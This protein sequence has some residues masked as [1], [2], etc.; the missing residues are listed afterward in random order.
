MLRHGELFAV[1]DRH[2]DALPSETGSHGF[3]YGGTRFLSEFSLW[4]EGAR[5]ALLGSTVRDEDALLTV[6]LANPDLL[7]GRETPI[8][9]D[10]IHVFR[11]RFACEDTFYESVRLTNH[12]SIAVEF[13]L[14]FDFA[15]DFAD[16]F[17][18]R[19]VRRAF[20]G[21]ARPP[22][23]SASGLELSYRGLDGLVR[24]TVV[25]CRPEPRTVT[26]TEIAYRVRL[27]PKQSQEIFLSITCIIGGSPSRPPRRDGE[28]AFQRTCDERDGA[29]RRSC[30]IRTSNESFN[31][32]IARST[33][34]LRMMVSQTGQG[35]YPFAGVPWF[36]AIF[37]RDGIITARELLWVDPAVARGVLLT[38]AATQAKDHSDARDAE[39]GKIVHEI[40]SGEM[41]ELGEVPFGC[42]YGTVDATPLFIMLAHGYHAQTGDLATIR[43]L[44]PSILAALEWIE[45]HGDLD[46]DGFIEY[47]RRAPDG[48][49]Q[50]GWKDS[51][52][53]IFHADG[54]PAEGPIALCE[55]QGY[56]YAA[57]VAVA[58]LASLLGDAALSRHQQ[59]EAAALRRRF[60]DRFWC[61]ELGTFVLAL[62]GDKEPCR[63]RT[64]NAGHCLFS[65]IATEEQ[66]LLL[67]STLMTEDAFS[68]WGL[69]T[70]SARERRYNPM[71][72]H[73]GSV[74]PHDTAIGA[75][76]M[77]RY[78]AREPVLR[79]LDG[80]FQASAYMDF[81]RLPELFCGFHARPGQGP[82]LYPL[83]CSPQAW[84]AGSVFMLL[85][86]C[87]GLEIHGA[88]R[89]AIFRRPV[90]PSWLDWVE[91]TGL[92]V[93]DTT[94]DLLLRRVR[95]GVTIELVS[96]VGDATVQVTKSI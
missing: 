83:A 12:G 4:M 36:N 30:R 3:Y 25:Q 95:A 6:D 66:A 10:T 37:G 41:A 21:D 20:R 49:V 79:L 35:I 67:S 50:Q 93:G 68:G 92:R 64:S 46:G 17:E 48:L 85:E 42:Y 84:A 27:E 88:A 75:A 23:R 24:S 16:I 8:L 14:S 28:V 40:R 62:D 78:G 7:R 32:W 15:S 5:P 70:V 61:E 22:R 69:R 51:N 72:Y 9:R 18:V 11:S 76:G 52:D 57:R 90:L 82:T 94:L 34:D 31:D 54:R 45:T 26:D 87:L 77:A 55:V 63:V 80:L 39:P 86:A 19:G 13:D 89:T 65:G 96:K 2:G 59:S 56:A 91:L 38:L 60:T 71:S 44:W 58:E 73:N 43:T 1:F 81:A 47:E 74:W 29:R 33:A 53:S